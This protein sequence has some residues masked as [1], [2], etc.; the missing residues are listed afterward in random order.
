MSKP[1]QETMDEVKIIIDSVPCGYDYG[2]R[3]N[4]AVAVTLQKHKDEIEKLKKELLSAKDKWHKSGWDDR[5]QE[6]YE[7]KKK[8]EKLEIQVVVRDGAIDAYKSKVAELEELGK[9]QGYW[10]LQTKADR[11]KKGL[12]AIKRHQ[13]T[14]IGKNS[15][16]L[17]ATWKIATDAL[18]EVK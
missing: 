15:F 18:K 2:N 5:Q 4:Y 16:E 13:E 6:I 9:V 11:Y 12:E 14:V 7:L 3:V 8:V 10:K 17:S 1:S